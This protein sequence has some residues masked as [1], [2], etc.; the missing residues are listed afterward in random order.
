LVPPLIFARTAL[1]L[2]LLIPIL[3]W[4]I[5]PEANVLAVVDT[6]KSILRS[7][8]V[9]IA[10]YLAPLKRT[11]YLVIRKQSWIL[12]VEHV[13]PIVRAFG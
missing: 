4:V 13:K 5:S 9:N 11:R 2:S 12:T 6:R 7:V 3:T 1:A 8:K 10:P